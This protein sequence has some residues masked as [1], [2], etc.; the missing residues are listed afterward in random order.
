M[1]QHLVYCIKNMGQCLAI[2][3]VD[4]STYLIYMCAILQGQDKQQLEILVLLV[5]NVL[6]II[7]HRQTTVVINE[8]FVAM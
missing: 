2:V 1:K 4:G 7:L 6:H 3:M 5:Y 8:I